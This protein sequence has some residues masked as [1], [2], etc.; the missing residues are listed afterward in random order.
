MDLSFSIHKKER[1][2]SQTS[3]LFEEVERISEGFEDLESLVS[4]FNNISVA[5]KIEISKQEILSQ[6]ESTVEDMD[7]LIGSIERNIGE[8]RELT[9]EFY[10]ITRQVLDTYFLS[11]EH[12]HQFI[13]RYKNDMHNACE[14]LNDEIFSIEKS[15]KNFRLFS[16]SFYQIYSDT[17][18]NLWNLDKIIGIIRQI[19]RKYKKIGKNATLQKDNLMLTNNIQD[20]EIKNNRLQSVVKDFTIFL[21]KKKAA[22]IEG[23]SVEDGTDQ[24]EIT[25]F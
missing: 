23:F 15:L 6:M 16:D 3:N 8:S 12:E 11:T 9:K 17:S 7:E 18:A 4:K 5:S 13:N 25:F 24:G 22:E 21:H 14:K 10:K 20:W 2:S 19:I 1:I